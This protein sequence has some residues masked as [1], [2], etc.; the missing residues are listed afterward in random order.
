MED[1]EILLDYMHD[2]S[3][4]STEI[5]QQLKNISEMLQGIYEKM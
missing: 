5:A 1:E 4:A 2:I 3:I